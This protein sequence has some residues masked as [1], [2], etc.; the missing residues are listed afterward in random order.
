MHQR[1]FHS[2]QAHN[3][4]NNNNKERNNNSKDNTN[5]TIGNTK[6]PADVDDNANTA[7][8]DDMIGVGHNKQDDDFGTAILV[9][10]MKEGNKTAEDIEKHLQ[11][12]SR[13]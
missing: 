9:A 11:F 8:G 12:N 2:T 4:N 5:A 10:A 13:K 6:R 1:T 3:S 7:I